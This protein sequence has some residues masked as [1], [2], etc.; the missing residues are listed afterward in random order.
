MFEYRIY[1]SVYDAMISRKK[2]IEVRLY[3]EKSEKIKPGDKI[4]FKVLD[5][6]KYLIVMVTNKYIFDNVEKLWENKD[7]VLKSSMEL[8]KQE[9]INALYEIFGKEKVQN[10]KLVGI[11][12]EIM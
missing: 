10:S 11:E 5:S 2:N 7:V 1:Q 3:N 8:S 6:D 9:V 4:K 12:F